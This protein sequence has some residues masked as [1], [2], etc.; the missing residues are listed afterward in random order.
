MYNCKSLVLMEHDWIKVS[1]R[2]N[3]CFIVLRLKVHTT[4]SNEMK[5]QSC[6]HRYLIHHKRLLSYI[7]VAA[8][9]GRCWSALNLHTRI[10]KSCLIHIVTHNIVVLRIQSLFETSTQN[11]Q[12]WFMWFLSG[13]CPD[14]TIRQS[15]E[16]GT[17]NVSF[18]KPCFWRQWHY[19]PEWYHLPLQVQFRPQKSWISFWSLKNN[20]KLIKVTTA[21]LKPPESICLCTFSGY[22]YIL[23]CFIF[24][25]HYLLL[26]INNNISP[27][28]WEQTVINTKK[29]HWMAVF[30]AL[31][32]IIISVLERDAIFWG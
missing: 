10:E 32:D 21:L 14:S 12:K 30:F 29:R 31:N 6:C 2:G 5:T 4:S 19:T 18:P 9:E 15:L 20:N 7:V 24:T 16:N 3:M 28:N 22:M 27:I 26:F 11:I 17:S 13:V 8:V 25:L 23:C 1:I